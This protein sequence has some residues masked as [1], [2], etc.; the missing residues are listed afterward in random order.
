[1]TVVRL[2]VEISGRCAIEERVILGAT[3]FAKFE[4]VHAETRRARRCAA[5]IL[6]MDRSIGIGHSRQET[7]TNLLVLHLHSRARTDPP[8]SRPA[9]VTRTTRAD[10][11][12]HPLTLTYPCVKASVGGGSIGPTSPVAPVPLSTSPPCRNAPTIRCR[13][14][15][16][17]AGR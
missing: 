7:H 4:G 1:M 3:S 9:L 14:S 12:L 13:A 17:S 10:V 8:P 11:C 5:E 6:C 16:R 2:F 15:S